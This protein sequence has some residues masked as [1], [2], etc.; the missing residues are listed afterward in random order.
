MLSATGS[1]PARCSCSSAC[2]TT[3]AT[4]YEIADF[5]G[6]WKAVPVFGG[7][8]V[9]ATFA[10]IGLPGFSGFVGEFLA[11]LGTFLTHRWY[12]VVA[13]TGVILA[14]VYL[15]WAVQRAFTGEPDGRERRAAR[16]LGSASSRRSCRCSGSVLFLGFY[17][18][19]VLDRLEP[20][21]DELVV[22]VDTHA[23]TTSGGPATA[24]TDGQSRE[25]A[26]CSRVE[27]R[28]DRKPLAVPP[29][30]WVVDRAGAVAVRAPR[31]R[32]CCCARWCD[33]R[34]ASSRSSVLHRDRRRRGVRC[35]HRGAC[36]TSCSDDGPYQAISGHGRGR[37]LLRVRPHGRPRRHAAR[38]VPL[39]RLPHARS[40]SRGPSTSRCCCC[41]A[42]GMM[43]MASANDLVVVFLALEIL[44]IALYV[45]A[46]FDR[47]RLESQEAGLKY[48]VLGAFSSAI[49]LYGIALTYG[50][51]GTTS[52]TGIAD[53]PR[54]QRRSLH[55]AC[56]SR[57]SRSC[58]SGSGSRW[59]RRRSTCG[60]PTSTRARPRR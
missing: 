38:G 4:R 20:T 11:L 7:L 16:H 5:G 41:S 54:R 23:T 12:A 57:A 26:P 15:L 39:G 30:D 60:R 35:V 48:F 33:S 22:H 40:G 51:T 52:L 21:V 34:R 55:A 53:V 46:A 8:F 59:R 32:S 28:A 44:S 58:S 50:A 47:R 14:A 13:T 19:P 29:I 2:S 25:R 24:S 45:L 43:I 6:L 3:A 17:P 9:A 42:T 18:K 27:Q 31:S 1:P 37:R 36:G 56:S 10:S 49:F